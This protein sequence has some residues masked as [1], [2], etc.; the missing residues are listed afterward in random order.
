MREQGLSEDEARAAARRAFGNVA[1]R[2]SDSTNPAAGFGGIISGRIFDS[3]RPCC[4]SLRASRVLAILTL[5]LGIGANTTI[6]S[7]I[8]AVALRS[9]PL[10]DPQQ[11]VLFEWTARSGSKHNLLCTFWRLSERWR[12]KYS[13]PLATS[14]SFSYPMFEQIKGMHDVLSGAL[15]FDR[16]NATVRVKGHTQRLRG[17]NVSGDFFST[18]GVRAAMGQAIEGGDDDISGAEPVIV[19]SYRYWRNELGA[20]SAGIG[21]QQS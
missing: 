15:A 2:R 17:M 3:V 20:D 12:R 21:K 18:L 5:A 19:L 6:F 13:S 9:L 10:P 11:L 1:K 7:L 14:C 4:A 8:N 16:V